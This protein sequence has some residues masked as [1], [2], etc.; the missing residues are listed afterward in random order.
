MSLLVLTALIRLT[1]F[2]CTLASFRRVDLVFCGTRHHRFLWCVT[3]IRSVTKIWTFYTTEVGFADLGEPRTR[4]GF[5][6]GYIKRRDKMKT[7][8]I[9]LRMISL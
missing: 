7:H 6:L 9:N 1:V 5:K 3:C 4:H 2:H 8:S